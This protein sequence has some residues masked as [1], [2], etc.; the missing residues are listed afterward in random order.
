MRR[1]LGPGS[2]AA[3]LSHALEDQLGLKLE[4]RQ[5]QQEVLVIMRRSKLDAFVLAFSLDAP[6]DCAS[7]ERGRESHNV[8]T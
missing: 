2:S 5:T 1:G 6:G 7:K 8:N 3:A 4:A